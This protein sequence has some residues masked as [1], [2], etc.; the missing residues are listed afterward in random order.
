M[1]PKYVDAYFCECPNCGRFE[2]S[3]TIQA[4]FDDLTEKQRALLSHGIWKGK[5]ATQRFRVQKQHVQAAR[6]GSL[7]N[8]AE[9][10]ERFILFV[11]D[12]QGDSPSKTVD[13]PPAHLCAK[14]GALGPK[15]VHFIANTAVKRGLIQ[16]SLT[17]GAIT[18][19]LTFDGWQC[20]E[21][22]KRGH[23]ESR[24]AFMAMPFGVPSVV[25]MVDGTFREAVAE[26]GFRLKRVDEEPKAGV[27]V[28]RM[29]VEIQTSR[30]LIADLT[31]RNPG[32]Y[33]EA[34]YAEGLGK[35][36]I[37][38]CEKTFF[39]QKKTHFDTNSS[40]TVIWD[41]NDTTKAAEDLK[42]TIRATLPFEAKM[43][44]E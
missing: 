13:Y 43:P 42:A 8:P 38:T 15:D 28:N 40:Q 5:A 29:K 34:G 41:L 3:R 36:V 32:A 9:Q 27:I 22:L 26:T 39:D 31:D 33:W 21:E 12:A 2:Y 16:D 24:S 17:R 10:L 4:S 14:I 30:F 1:L 25:E 6:E 7:P 23:S 35:P 20:Y 44:E 37:Y 11:G 19:A 18:T